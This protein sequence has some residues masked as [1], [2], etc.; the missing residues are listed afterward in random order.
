MEGEGQFGFEFGFGTESG[1]SREP[2]LQRVLEGEGQFEFGTESGL[3]REPGLHRV[4]EGEGQFELEFEFET[5]S[6]LSREPG[7]QRV[8]LRGKSSLVA[9][10]CVRPTVRLL[11]FGGGYDAQPLAQLAQQMGWLVTVTDECAA[12]ALPVRFPGVEQTVHLKR[13]SAVSTLQPNAHTAAVL[14]SHNYG[15]DKAVLNQLIDTEAFYIGILGPRKRFQRLDS[16]FEGR[17][18]KMPAV[19]APVGLDIGAETPFEIAMAIVSEVQAV[20]AD[21]MGGKLKAREG[22]I[23]QRK[24][25]AG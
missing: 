7:L 23:H 11:I 9:V 24:A 4:L 13:G 19:H 14:L 12:K 20:Y 21:R 3:S 17:L 6:D 15:Y 18:G 22:F 1:L 5:E 8:F 16:E 25:F 2:G 10:E